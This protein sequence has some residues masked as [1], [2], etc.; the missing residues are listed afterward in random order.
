M[1]NTDS[2]IGFA[3]FQVLIATEK[4]GDY[5]LAEAQ[6]EDLLHDGPPPS[7][8]GSAKSYS[9]SKA[10]AYS[11]EDLAAKILKEEGR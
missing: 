11:L 10:V 8:L 9:R 5:W 2:T 7:F 3:D 4:D 6:I 1:T